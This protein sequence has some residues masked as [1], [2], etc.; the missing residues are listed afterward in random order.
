MKLPQSDT[1]VIEREKVVDYLLNVSHPFGASK[2]AFFQRF[3]FRA[4]NWEELA[5]ALRL[6]GQTHDVK[7]TIET[8]FGLR[9][10][11]ESRLNAADGRSPCVRSVWQRD[12][13]TVAPRLITAYPLDDR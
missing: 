13:G 12:H 1:T 3:G 11:V 10:E 5:H 2:A 4:Q 9:Y 8:G 7:R 6:H